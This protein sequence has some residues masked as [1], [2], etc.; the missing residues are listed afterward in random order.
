MSEAKTI[1]HVVTT[2]KCPDYDSPERNQST[3]PAANLS[4]RFRAASVGSTCDGYHWFCSCDPE[5][6]MN[7]SRTEHF[8][9][10][11]SYVSEDEMDAHILAHFSRVDSLPII[12]PDS[13][14]MKPA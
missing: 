13:L 11:S 14:P 3:C 10:G 1:E 8:T 6:S 7:N 9:N 12:H 5:K 4:P 2:S